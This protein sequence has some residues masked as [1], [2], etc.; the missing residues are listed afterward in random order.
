LQIRRVEMRKPEE[1]DKEIKENSELLKVKL[2]LLENGDRE[3]MYT[4]AKIFNK[5]TWLFR[6]KEGYKS[7]EE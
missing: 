3:M 2:P 7:D 4:L 6:E 1:I 5:L